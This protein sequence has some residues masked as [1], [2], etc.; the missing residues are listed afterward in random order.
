ME[1][2]PVLPAEPSGPPPPK[3]IESPLRLWHALSYRDFRLYWSGQS[4]SLVGVWMQNAAL[5][6]VV[7]GLTGSATKIAAVSF[8]SSVPVV[9][10]SLFAGVLADRYSRRR[11]MIGCHV[12]F[13]LLATA[14]GLLVHL[15][16]L[17]LALVYGLALLL[18]L[19]SAIELPSQRALLRQ[20]VPPEAIQPAVALQGASFHGSRLIGPALAGV[21]MA[22]VSIAAVFIINAASYVAVLVSLIVIRPRRAARS[23]QG[24]WAALREGLGYVRRERR[25]AALLGFVGLTTACI[26][27]YLAVFTPLVVKELFGGDATAFGLLMSSS[28]FGALVG[29]LALVRVRERWR[30]RTIVLGCLVAGSMLVWIS[31]IRSPWPACPLVAVMTFS[32]SLALGLCNTILQLSV[33]EHLLGRVMSLH[34]LLFAGVMPTAALLWGSLAGILGLA[35]TILVMGGVYLALALPWLAVARVERGAEGE[36]ESPS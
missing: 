10:L 1:E 15:G 9:L 2:P 7:V 34:T 33:P 19:V 35:P 32:V 11:L 12:A 13:T 18:G 22:T 23:L 25:V 6:W 26:F 3:R 17:T 21:V 28:G 5:A 29:S 20:L 4:V 36:V 14:A 27:P 31:F 24:G 30:G 16:Q 8:T